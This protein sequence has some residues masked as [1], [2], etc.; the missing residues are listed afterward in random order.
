MI[1]IGT[2]I[3]DR[4]EVL[5]EIGRGGMSVVYLAMNNR[6]NKSVVVKDI[7]KRN[8]QNDSILINSL[9]VES[10]MLKKLDHSALP[11]IYDI[12]D[13][14]A[15]DIY[16]VMDYIE[17]ESLNQKLKREHVMTAKNV[18]EWAKQLTDVLNY[19]HTRKPH[20]I[21]Y[22]DMKPDNIM[23][24]PEGKIKLIDFGI[25]REYKD[26]STT[27]T[28]NL[29]TRAFAAPEQIAGKQTDARTDI[30]SLGVTLY[31]LV[32]GKSLNEEPFELKPIRYWNPTLPEGLEYIINKCTQGHPEDRYQNCEELAYDLE[33]IDKLTKEYRSK[34]YKKMTSFSVSC[35]LL[36][37]FI[38]L[39]IVGYNGINSD[40][41]REYKKLINESDRL[42]IDGNHTE[43]I[44]ILDDAITQVDSKKSEAY[45]NLIN[46]Y[47]NRKEVE[48]GLAK[49]EG[50]INDKYGDVNKNDEVLFKV[51]MTYLDTKNYPLALKYFQMVDV[52]K[53][54]DAQYYKT[55]T[56]S[57]SSM[58]VEYEE[59]ATDL[60]KFNMYCDELPNDDKKIANYNSLANI[61]TSYKG[62]IENAN[63]KV[64]KIINSANEALISLDDE[65]L[66]LRYEVEFTTKLAQAYHSRG[67]NNKDKEAARED[68][69]E[70]IE[71]YQ[72]LLS[73][74]GAEREDMLIKIGEVYSDLED[75]PKAVEQLRL[76]IDKYPES[77][78]AYVKLVN[79]LLDVEQGKSEELRNYTEAKKVY[80]K[81]KDIN[82]ISEDEEFKKLERRMS[83]LEIM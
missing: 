32:T 70:S 59:L 2:V 74:D 14:G 38:I 17:G 44:K 51:A 61:Y 15:G 13:D 23:L 45:I 5:K 6:L 53:I 28:T 33:N 48:A 57:L 75:Y 83:N 62:R 24:T 73:M 77:I 37:F 26:E 81:A 55:L 19:L 60:E 82:E 46:I 16:V 63:D 30:Y 11:K 52:K 80:E 12:I 66:D 27:D 20:P 7:R 76:T 25:S 58:N 65:R 43:A 49:V 8:N 54:P 21:I 36:I 10:N 79:L 67:I 39:T 42:L 40:R 69:K 56:T 41:L 3:D 50:Y 4:Y 34:L 18:I 71:Y 22:R 78:K 64:I 35:A 29:G 1:K 47:I 31:N 72:K 68:L 9:I